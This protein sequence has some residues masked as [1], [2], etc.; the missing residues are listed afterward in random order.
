MKNIVLLVLLASLFSCSTTSEIQVSKVG[1]EPE[2]YLERTIYVLPQTLFMVSLEY[3]KETFIPGPYRLYTEKFLGLED[4]IAQ[5]GISYRLLNVDLES[6][7]EPDPDHYYSVNLIKGNFDREAY[8]E[9]SDHGFILDPS[10]RFGT[11]KERID[12]ESEP[13]LPYFTDLSVN[14]NLREVTDTLYKTIIRD[15]SYVRVPV[16]RSHREAKTLEQKAEEAANFIIRIRNRRFRLLA[17]QNELF[18]EGDALAVS[19]EELDKLEK[20][21][22]Q[23]FL[24]K[25][26]KE[27]FKKSFIVVPDAGSE[28]RSYTFARFSPEAGLLKADDSAGKALE[29]W[30]EPQHKVL[31]LPDATLEQNVKN[32][33]FYR[34]PDIAEVKVQLVNE[35]LY[36]KRSTV[37]QLGNILSYPVHLEKGK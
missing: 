11:E 12:A 16:L 31:N 2:E 21:Y 33:I 26:I 19:I 8:L 10:A 34:V 14:R 1:N 22:L 27:K 13:E 18:P 24:G 7:T 28:S 5:R 25:R 29:L 30:I 9:L 23:L 6:F 3:E 15:S 36:E 20:E 35:I 17:G 4:Y 37:Y 32:Q